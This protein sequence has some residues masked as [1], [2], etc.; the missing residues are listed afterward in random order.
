MNIG[1]DSVTDHLV[2]GSE[3]K[4]FKTISRSIPESMWIVRTERKM[5]YVWRSKSGILSGKTISPKWVGITT[6]YDHESLLSLGVNM[7]IDNYEN[8]NNDSFVIISN[9]SEIL[10]QCIKKSLKKLKKRN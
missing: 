4:T 9:N 1:I 2:I 8:I 5:Y 10:K 6:V 3:C 7:V